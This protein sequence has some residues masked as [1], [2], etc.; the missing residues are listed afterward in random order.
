MPSKISHVLPLLAVLAFLGHIH[1]SKAAHPVRWEH[2][3]STASLART[4]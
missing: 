2:H 4:R 1:Y 3:S